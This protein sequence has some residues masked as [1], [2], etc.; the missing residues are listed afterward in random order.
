M[1]S[2]KFRDRGW[3]NLLPETEG[4]L[5]SGSTAN[6]KLIWTW[7][8]K[9]NEVHDNAPKDTIVSGVP[10]RV[11][12]A[13]NHNPEMEI[14]KQMAK[15]KERNDFAIFTF[16]QSSGIDDQM[17]ARRQANL[18]VRG[19]LDTGQGNQQWAASHGLIENGVNIRLVPPKAPVRKLHHKIMVLDK[20]VVIAG[21]FN[22]TGNANMLNDENIIILGDLDETDSESIVKQKELGGFAF[23][24]I[25]RIYETYGVMRNE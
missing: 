24:E 5:E 16:P 12:F 3:E 9:L 8:G 20:Q 13:P 11:L 2:L 21:S 6:S 25:N 1:K 17:I 14:M 10:L 4:A 7:S 23:T 22:Y 18:V 15:A 19:V